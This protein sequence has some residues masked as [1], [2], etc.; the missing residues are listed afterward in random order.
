MNSSFQTKR[1][2][3]G[4]EFM[5]STPQLETAA[6]RGLTTRATIW[7]SRDCALAGREGLL[8]RATPTC[9]QI[10]GIDTISWWTIVVTRKVSCSCRWR[11]E[12]KRWRREDSFDNT[13][14]LWSALLL[15]FQLLPVHT[16]TN[17]KNLV[18]R[19]LS[20]IQSMISCKIAS[21][22][23]GWHISEL[24]KAPGEILFPETLGT[25]VCASDL[26]KKW[27]KMCLPLCI[28]VIY[29]SLFVKEVLAPVI[30]NSP[31]LIFTLF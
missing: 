10:S 21:R 9:S 1:R 15:V 25:C 20:L 6:S 26:D 5:K 16:T 4:L 24:C 30:W 17:H 13:I 2:P 28:I 3:F 8:Y 7:A 18:R 12:R 23:R 11:C 19:S 22:V 31:P 14:Q 27:T 29:N